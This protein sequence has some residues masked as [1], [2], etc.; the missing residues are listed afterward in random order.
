VID[1]DRLLKLRVVIARFGEMDNARW[2]N[3]NG[4]LGAIGATVLQRNFPRTYRFAAARSVFAVARARCDELFNPPKGITL[5]NVPAT[6][7]DE[8]DAKW[9]AWIQRRDEWEPF[10]AEVAALSASSD[11][12][13]LLRRLNLVTAADEEAVRP[14]HRSVEARAVQLPGVHA[15][16]DELLGRLSLG[17]SK[18][19]PESLTIPYARLED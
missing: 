9:E 17:F 6:I 13:D 3:T 4:Q 5:W 2:W 7:E 14:L 1:F 15:A 10:F 18:G 19:G 12:A 8:F 11:P 16:S